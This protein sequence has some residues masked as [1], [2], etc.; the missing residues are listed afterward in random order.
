MRSARFDTARSRLAGLSPRESVARL[1]LQVERR[2]CGLRPG[3]V[4]IPGFDMPYLEGG[5]GQPLVLLHGFGADRDNFTRVAAHLTGRF[6]VIIPDLPGF[7]DATRDPQAGY[8]IVDQVERLRQFMCRLDLPHAHVAGSSMGGAIA[9]AYAARYPE[10]VASL[11]LLCPH[12]VTSAARSEVQ[13]AYFEENVSMLTAA[14]PDAFRAV[15]DLMFVKRPWIPGIVQAHLAHRAAADYA[16]HRTILDEI[17]EP[18]FLEDEARGIEAP[19]LIVWGEH[20]RVLD[21]S[22]GEVLRERIPRAELRVM[23][24][25]GHLPMV[26]SPRAA[27]RDYRRFVD[28]LDRA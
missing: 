7:G 27:A 19:T 6:R 14:T 5:R 1:A 23:R 8:R 24:G 11:W 12:G 22:G 9:G 21:V 26:E 4:S 10:N 28:R 25:R 18:P 16:L 13:T 17:H 15:V 20:D 2:R 3:V